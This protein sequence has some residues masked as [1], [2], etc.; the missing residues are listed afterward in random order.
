MLTSLVSS[1]CNSHRPPHAAR[2]FLCRCP[3]TTQTISHRYDVI[4]RVDFVDDS[5]LGA[6]NRVD[7]GYDP[8]G[9]RT[10]MTG[11]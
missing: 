9:N 8:A 1:S 2:V 10:S 6:T 4:G 7:Y 11:T 5:Y 3:L